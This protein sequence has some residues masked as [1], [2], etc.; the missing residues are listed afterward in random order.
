MDQQLRLLEE[1]LGLV[2][3]TH[4]ATPSCLQLQSQ[5]IQSH[6]TFMF[7]IYMWCIDIH[8]CEQNTY[9]YKISQKKMKNQILLQWAIMQENIDVVKACDR[10][11]YVL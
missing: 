7:N 6:L 5:G 2:P 4:M 11:C 1:E 8:T 10:C 9:T 3:S